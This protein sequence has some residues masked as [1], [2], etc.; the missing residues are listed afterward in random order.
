MKNRSFPAGSVILVISLVVTAVSGFVTW[1]LFPIP[2][3]TLFNT[4]LSIT[5]AGLVLCLATLAVTALRAKAVWLKA[6]GAVP[7]ILAIVIASASII[8]K[9]DSRLLPNMSY[10]YGLSA[11]EWKEDVR[12]FAEQFPE[13]H[14]RLYEMMDQERFE[15]RTAALVDGIPDLSENSVKMEL[16][17]LLALP[18]DAHSF[19]NVF[20]HKLDWHALPFKLWLFDDGVYVL[21]AGREHRDMIGARL[22]EIGDTPVAEAY[23]RLRPYL[24]AENEFNWKERFIYCI[25]I[26]EFLDAAG[27]VEDPRKVD[28]T[29]ETRAGMKLTIEVEPS[30]YLPVLYW[31]TISTVDNGLPYVLSNER[32]D[33]WWF[34][35]QEETGTL[36]LQFNACQREN[37]DE[38]IEDFVGRLGE[39]VDSNEFERFV[40]DIRANGG[41][42]ASVS[43]QMA[44]LM[45]GTARIDRPGRLFVLTSR[46]TY[47][48]AVM[49]LSLIENNTKAVIVGEPTGQGPFFCGGPQLI[50]LPNS[51]L[52]LFISSRYN[53]CAPFD[54]GRDWIMPDLPVEYTMTDY[55]EG[56]DPMMEAVLE[57]GTP[58]VTAV[59]IGISE[60]EKYT[61][62]YCLGSYQILTVEAAGEGLSFSVDDFFE[63]SYRNV[64]SDLYPGGS[65]LFHTDI[66]GV[67]LFFSEGPEGVAEGVTLRWRGIDTYAE[68]SP[69]GHR[70]PMELFA[71]GRFGEA[72]AA[73]YMERDVYLSEVPDLETRLNA[74]GY[75][76]LGEEKDAP[77]VKILELNVRLFPESAN[78]YDSL[79]EAYMLSGMRD[80]AIKNYE[81]AV[82]L[83]PESKNALEIL[84][85]L[86]KGETRDRE[87]RKWTG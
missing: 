45:S 33:N 50:E 7:A 34:E 72:V 11:D 40:V 12:Y 77:A 75:A 27:I 62:R 26:V 43:R 70:L 65:H 18:N 46:K 87:T 24:A 83:N 69:E 80:L 85:H 68:R 60:Q 36:Y 47:S 13:R 56:R 35:Y 2:F 17:K 38:R 49:F 67:E 54:D 39:W 15:A 58:V 82:E 79:G 3:G 22:V 76:L 16:Y 42:D 41:G 4:F 48:A 31:A 10:R 59:E 84:G 32:R 74:M 53:R 28:L 25:S 61:G 44:G 55:L 30:H 21:D 73:L 51:G 29:F 20:T 23:R 5:V 64:S 52:E 8:L 1:R 57:Y 37:G 86:R 81:K 9:V 63:G 6:I 78:T 66:D 14:P 19:P 71:E